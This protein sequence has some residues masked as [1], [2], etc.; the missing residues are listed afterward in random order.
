[1]TAHRYALAKY[2]K[3]Y[4]K[5]LQCPKCGQANKFVPYYDAHENR[6]CA[7]DFGKCDRVNECGYWAKPNG[8]TTEY[9][10]RE[11]APQLPMITISDKVVLRSFENYITKNTL[12]AAFRERFGCESLRNAFLIYRI[13]AAD[14]GSCIFWQIDKDNICRTGKLI[15]YD[16]TGHRKKNGAVVRWVHKYFNFADHELKQCVFG[17]HRLKYS[18]KPVAIV[19]SEKTAVLMSIID[20]SFIWLAVGGSNNIV[21]TGAIETLKGRE[22]HLFSD[23]GMFHYWQKFAQCYGWINERWH[24]DKDVKTGDDILDFELTR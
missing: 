20:P 17:E 11:P 24:I 14:D 21:A 16:E 18:D 13:G 22:V 6:L 9:V 3:Q 12:F 23:V 2:G 10:E 19:E 7:E 15:T 4:R 1:M 5:K 8:Q